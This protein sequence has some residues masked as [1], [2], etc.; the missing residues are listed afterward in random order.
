MNYPNWILIKARNRA[1]RL[2]ETIFIVYDCNK[3]D[4]ATE[5][6]LETYFMGISDNNILAAITPSGELEE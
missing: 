5:C 6:E 3:Y 1:K 4:T 2:Q